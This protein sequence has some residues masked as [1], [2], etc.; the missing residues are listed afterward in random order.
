MVFLVLKKTFFKLEL[1]YLFMSDNVDGETE[2]ER[3]RE[4][5][6]EIKNEVTKSEESIAKTN[7]Y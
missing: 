3:E 4:R 2:R 6:R 7:R 5:E 1:V